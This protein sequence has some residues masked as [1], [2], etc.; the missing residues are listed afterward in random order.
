MVVW[1]KYFALTIPNPRSMESGFDSIKQ[2]ICFKL[3]LHARWSLDATVLGKYS[4]LAITIPCLM[5]L[6][7]DTEHAPPS[8][9]NFHDLPSTSAV[10]SK[11]TQNSSLQLLQHYLDPF[12]YLAFFFLAFWWRHD[13]GSLLISSNFSTRVLLVSLEILRGWPSC[14]NFTRQPRTSPSLQP[15]TLQGPPSATIK[16]ERYR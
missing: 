13:S 7:C 3:L 11:R 16:L 5:K 15:S 10:P 2:V 1:Y 8:S 12:A 14:S 9:S 6:C 4:A